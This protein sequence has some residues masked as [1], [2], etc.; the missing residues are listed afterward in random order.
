[1]AIGSGTRWAALGHT[2]YD[3]NGHAKVAISEAF[4]NTY[5]KMLNGGNA[6]RLKAREHAGKDRREVGL[7]DRAGYPTSQLEALGA[8]DPDAFAVECPPKEK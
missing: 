5:E 1:V 3:D 2:P 7:L 6:M 4:R 8:A